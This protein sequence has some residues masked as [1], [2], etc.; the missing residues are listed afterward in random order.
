M[1][2]TGSKILHSKMK[3]VKH[4][5]ELTRK[6]MDKKTEYLA[7]RVGKIKHELWLKSR[8]TNNVYLTSYDNHI[9]EKLQ[10]GATAIFG[11]AGYFLED[12]IENLTVI[13]TQKIVKS[14][15]PKAV[16]VKGRD[17]IGRLFPKKFNNFIV[18]NNRSDLWVDKDGL[19][20]HIKNYKRSMSDG[21]LFFYSMRDTQFTPWNRLKINHYEMFIGL[22]KKIESLGFECVE[23]K[24]DFANGDGNENPDTTNGNIKY[25]FKCTK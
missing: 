21:C 3:I 11:S 8:K 12:C 6:T 20:E 23:S 5:N 10:P 2:P 24:I 15:Y 25:I 13:E 1:G 4:Y 9:L 7:Y 19:C 18:T 22:A 17:E 16:I 14:F